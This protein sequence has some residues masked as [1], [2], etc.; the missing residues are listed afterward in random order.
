MK[1]IFMVF[2]LFC[3]MFLMISCGDGSSSDNNS[4]TN[5]G[6]LGGE[7]YPNRTCDKGFICDAKHNVCL[8]DPGNPDNGSDKSDS[9]NAGKTDTTPEQP[10]DN[11]DSTPA[12]NIDTSDSTDDADLGD[13][14]P[15]G[16]S[17]AD[18]GDDG[19]TT[20]S[21]A[22]SGT[23]TGSEGDDSNLN[24][25]DESGNQ[26]LAGEI[27]AACT[28]ENNCKQSYNNG[29]QTAACVKDSEGFPGGYCTFFGDGTDSAACDSTEEL[30]YN[31]GG[32]WGGNGLCLHKC[33]KPSDCRK[34]YRCSN[35][36]QAC[37][38]DCKTAGYECVYGKCDTTDGVCLEI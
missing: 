18:S 26:A 3:V 25:G 21:G 7:C 19:D 20:D 9:D 5:F 10:D 33:T 37:L 22:D 23:D 17:G 15:D 16:D 30:F 38:P 36:I 35:K 2:A 31:F 8:K 1:K 4:V 13:S 12:D 24:T 28:N 34:G 32:S 29:D 6:K 14:Q 27:G 11:G